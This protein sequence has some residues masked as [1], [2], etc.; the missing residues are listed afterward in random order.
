MCHEI[1]PSVDYNES[2]DTKR[3]KSQGSAAAHLQC[4]WI[5]NCK[6]TAQHIGEGILKISQQLMHL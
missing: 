5:T 2:Y 6:L 1:K 3:T 4:D